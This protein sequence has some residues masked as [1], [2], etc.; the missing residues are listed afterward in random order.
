MNLKNPKLTTIL[1]SILV[2]TLSVLLL[3]SRKIKLG[4]EIALTQQEVTSEGTTIILEDTE[5]TLDGLSVSIPKDAHSENAEY[6]ISYAEIKSNGGFKNFNPLTPMIVIENGN[7]FTQELITLTIPISL[8]EGHFAMAFYYDEDSN[9]LEGI[10]LLSLTENEIVIGTKHFSKIVVSSISEENLKKL[11]ADSGFRPGKND[12]Q[13]ANRGSLI[14]P[15]GHCAGQSISAMWYYSEKTLKGGSNLYGRYDN[16]RNLIDGRIKTPKLWIDDSLGYRLASVVQEEINWESEER[17]LFNDFSGIDDRL[18]YLAFVYSIHLTRQP[19]YVAVRREGGG[20]AMIVYKAEKSI[21]YLADPNYYGEVREITFDTDTNKFKPYISGANLEEIKKGNGRE[22]PIIHYYAKTA[23]IPFDT[24]K[25]AWEA[26][27]NKT[28]GNDHFPDSPIGYYDKSD[29]DKEGEWKILSDSTNI[30]KQKDD[31]VYFSIR[32]IFPKARLTIYNGE[33]KVASGSRRSDLK[34]VEPPEIKLKEGKTTLGFYVEF[35]YDDDPTVYYV[36]FLRYSFT[37]RGE[38]ILVEK[39][40][41]TKPTIPIE[42]VGNWS[43]THMFTDIHFTE[44]IR[45]DPANYWSPDEFQPELNNRREMSLTIY[46]IGNGEGFYITPS[47]YGGN[48]DEEGNVIMYMDNGNRDTLA[49]V[50]TLQDS[51]DILFET[52]WFGIDAKAI[53]KGTFSEDFR[54]ISGIYEGYYLTTLMVTSEWEVSLE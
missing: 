15:N 6:K 30:P 53:W 27:E 34:Y 5:T 25:Q 1:L 50:E 39:E 35:G 36:D 46:P 22:Y 54:S 45:V 32:K 4:E 23:L 11:K 42:I 3:T 51:R 16:N 20:H 21:L 19:Q 18:T 10:P 28:I 13:F 7:I 26:V 8:P 40:V 43:G 14:S 9:S 2:L 24:V 48:I 52:P 41:E 44:F 17:K 49:T 33:K 47:I 29:D 12:W 31:V 37:Y 38:E